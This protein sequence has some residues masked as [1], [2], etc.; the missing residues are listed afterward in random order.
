MARLEH[1]AGPAAAASPVPTPRGDATAGPGLAWRVRGVVTTVDGWPV[2]GAVVTVVGAA[3]QQFGRGA[4]DEAGAFAVALSGTGTATFICA[5]P[6]VDPIAR[7]IT[8]KENDVTDL[9][10]IVLDSPHRSALPQPG[11]WAIDPAHS[12]IRAKARHLALSHVEGRFT[13]FAGEIRIA[14][15][16]GHSSVQ[17][18]IDAA[19]I[20][21]GNAD[22]DAHL[23]SGDFLDVERF[24][25]LSYRSDRVIRQAEDRWRVDGRLTIRDITREVPLDV[26]YLGSGPDPWGGFRVALVATTQLARR[27]Y[28]INWNMGLPGG[29]VL[30]GPTLRI[31]LQVQAVRQDGNGAAGPG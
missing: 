19:S 12:I 7:A 22:R 24:P 21:T 28:E 8:V 6:G 11:V 29:L 14:E 31:D 16:I 30:V 27:D 17:V 10:S 20:D 23:R 3:G 4:A 15:P 26:S 13:S 18:S 25:A 2:P 9:G 5:A 1:W